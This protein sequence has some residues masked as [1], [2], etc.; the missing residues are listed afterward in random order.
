MML[1]F[2]FS[3]TLRAGNKQTRSLM[4]AKFHHNDILYYITLV[5]LCLLRCSQM[6]SILSA[7]TYSISSLCKLA[8]EAKI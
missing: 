1:Y 5:K 4:K 6:L 7:L 2:D 3:V 8:L